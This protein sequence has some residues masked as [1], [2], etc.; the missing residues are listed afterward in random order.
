MLNMM[1]DNRTELL[2][3]SLFLL[4]VLLVLVPDG[5]ADAHH[6]AAAHFDPDDVVTLE[7]M[8]TELQFVN[9]H[10]WVHIDAVDDGGV[11]Q[12]WRCELSGATQ[13]IRR[14][15]TP[16]TLAPGQT[17]KIVGNGLG[18]RRTRAPCSLSF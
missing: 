5:D 11:A 2:G 12:S 10:A 15:W 8:I 13:L 18:E 4:A 9:P 3:R 16:E 7:G 14:G 1:S 17:V 6:G